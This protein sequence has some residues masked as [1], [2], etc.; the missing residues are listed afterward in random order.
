MP[1]IYNMS[2]V[3]IVICAGSIMILGCSD[4]SEIESV[5]FG[6]DF[7]AGDG[8]YVGFADY[9]VND[10]A[11]FELNNEHTAL[12]VEVT[13]P[14][15]ALMITGNN[16]NGDLFMYAKKKISGLKPQTTYELRFSLL[17]ATN[18]SNAAADTG[19][20]PGADVYVKAGASFSE[21]GV[22]EDEGIYRMTIEKGNHSTGGEDAAVLGTFG[23]SNPADD[24]DY[25]MRTIDN[26][27]D[28]LSVTTDDLGVLWLIVGTDSE[29]IGTT[30][31]YFYTL[32][33]RI[34][35]Q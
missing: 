20:S 31:I 33:L 13:N 14:V 4:T 22:Y 29:Y 9:P 23:D 30:T 1:K 35:R 7:T 8:W 5:S 2:L 21:P 10:A 3:I 19:G 34:D 32:A 12:P 11:S 24:T 15:P 16:L 6:Y 26:D 27:S 17:F 25:R 28:P 18:A